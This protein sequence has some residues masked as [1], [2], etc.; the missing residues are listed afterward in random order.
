MMHQQVRILTMI[1][2][3]PPVVQR[4]GGSLVL[5]EI[6]QHLIGLVLYTQ[7]SGSEAKEQQGYWLGKHGVQHKEKTQKE[8]KGP[9]KCST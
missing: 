8:D 2:P 1:L 9:K 6:P 5:I 4:A 3:L 7:N